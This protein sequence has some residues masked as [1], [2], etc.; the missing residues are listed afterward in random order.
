MK[1]S[2]AEIADAIQAARHTAG[3]GVV[4]SGYSIDSRTISP[5][6]CFFAIKG[7]NFDGHQFIPE[8][9]QRGAA[10]VVA[11]AGTPMPAARD[12]PVLSVD[13]TL[14]AL[15][16][17]AAYARHKWGR[18]VIGITG[19]AGKTTT[20]EIASLLLQ[21]RYRV[22]KTG[23]NFNNDYGLPLSILSL[24]EEHEVAVLELGM[25]RSGEI[26]RLSR[27]AQPDVGVVTNVRPVH[28]ENFKSIQGIA[29]AKRELVETLPAGGVA[30]LN[31]DDV[32]VRKF[33]RAFP[34]KVLTFGV[35]APATYK[36]SEIHIRGLEGSEFRLDYK[37][38]GHLLRV[39]LIGAHNI[40]NALPAI[41]VAHHL[42]VGFETINENLRS[43]KPASGRGE[44]L[45]FQE[46]FAVLNDS[47]N[48]NPAAMDAVIR[49][50]KAISGF[51]RKLLVVGEMLELGPKAQEFHR[52]CGRQAAA[53]RIDVI[54][55]VQGLA[56][57]ISQLARQAGYPVAVSP[58]FADS[59]TAGE[60]L[61][62]QVRCGD[63]IVV[64][65]SRGVKTEKVIE[66]LRRDHAI[67][68]M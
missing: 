31:N 56:A 19:S 7:P 21:A 40:S 55:A 27:I 60:W 15:Q 22:F 34:G 53:A 47:Y 54:A 4:P 49:F 28:L 63:F 39:P 51:Q 50:A 13:N 29:L 61:T 66:I 9:V 43:L 37:S 1:L 17:L 62:R 6:E 24:R 65:G 35:D 12:W 26:A 16:Q 20:K 45:R 23:G 3:N 2:G 11:C 25:S 5:G 58:F 59:A 46:G 18:P 41:A 48:S 44:I 14:L 67:K 42:G 38:K 57:E 36:A 32:H 64:K 10:L 68:S 8:A 33:G 30:V 52:D